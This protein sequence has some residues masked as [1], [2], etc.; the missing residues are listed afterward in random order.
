MGVKI[1]DVWKTFGRGLHQR[2]SLPNYAD[3][4]ENGATSYSPPDFLV[5]EAANLQGYALCRQPLLASRVCHLGGL[6]PPFWYPG[7]PFWH[8]GSTLKNPGSSRMD[9]RG[10][11]KDFIDFE[12]ILIFYF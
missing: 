1:A 3:P 7:G 5:R 8:L 6:V 4:T 11:E 10:L 12:L 9:T 2:G